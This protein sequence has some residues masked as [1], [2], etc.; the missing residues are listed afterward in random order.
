MTKNLID[1]ELKK[2]ADETDSIVNAVEKDEEELDKL[3]EDIILA[4]LNKNLAKAPPPDYTTVCDN[5]L[6]RFQY[7]CKALPSPDLFIEY[8]FYFMIAA[9]LARKVWWGTANS[10][11]GNLYPNLYLIFV[12]PPGIG[13]SLPANTAGRILSGLAEYY[14]DKKEGK[15]K[16][17]GMLNL[18][19]DSVTFEKLIIRAA[20]YNELTPWPDGPMKFY[21]HSSTTFCLGDEL[22]MLLTDQTKRVVSFLMKSWDCGDY[23]GD[24]IKHG[25]TIIKNI[26]LNFLGCT[27][28]NIMKDLM[29][30]KV[31]DSG[32]TGR[33]IFIYADKKR[34][35]IKGDL[36]ITES[37]INE[38]K[39][40]SQHLRKLCRI[41]PTP[42]KCS[43][44]A[45]EWL[46]NWVENK[47]DTR[48]NPNP[49]LIDYYAR[50]QAQLKKLAICH[51][52]ANNL[53]NEI[54]VEDFEAAECILLKTEPMMHKALTQ[55]GENIMYTIAE[56]MKIYLTTHKKVDRK[57]LMLD[58]FSMGDYRILQGSMQFLLETNQI[59][60]E[61]IDDKMMVSLSG[62][63][64]II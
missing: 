6:E 19:P 32:F 63:E 50:K 7:L 35:K 8:N 60:T 42:V 11:I 14:F 12:T 54:Q 24:T 5:N 40:L 18:G 59:K 20:S 52:Y 28:P 57:R 46:N 22:G 37:Q 15:F 4:K 53:D 2:Q 47:E 3:K 13:K 48:L 61:K 62:K 30:T 34:Q 39:I 64:Y 31:L 56:E 38:I 49:R 36:S 10:Y 21:H 45:R 17:R 33:S 44:E 23:E 41:S 43:P 16:V 51:H 27:T 55:S 25:A 29:K 26:C 58:F 1:P 9:C